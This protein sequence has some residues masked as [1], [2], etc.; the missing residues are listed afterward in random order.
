[1]TYNNALGFGPNQNNVPFGP[2]KLPLLNLNDLEISTT[3]R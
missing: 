2:T 1:M 3:R